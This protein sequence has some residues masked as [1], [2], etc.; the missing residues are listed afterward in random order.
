LDEFTASIPETT[1]STII[2]EFSTW[3]MT[4]AAHFPTTV[5]TAK[6]TF[7]IKTFSFWFPMVTVTCSGA[8]FFP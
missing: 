2:P 5:T 7:S 6:V 3:E 4:T 1:P 8:S